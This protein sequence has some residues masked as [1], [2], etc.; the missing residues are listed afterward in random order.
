MLLLE[1]HMGEHEAILGI[2]TSDVLVSFPPL[3]MKGLVGP[4]ATNVCLASTP[5]AADAQ[6]VPPIFAHYLPGGAVVPLLY[7]VIPYL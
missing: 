3:S 2:N 4:T 6:K 7:L 1:A 5:V